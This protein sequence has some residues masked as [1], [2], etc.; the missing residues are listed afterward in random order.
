MDVSDQ[1][2][3]RQEIERLRTLINHHNHRYHVLDSPEI[4]DSEYDR[5]MRRL[6]QLEAE[7]PEL[8]TPDSPTRRVGAA[9]LEEF[10]TVE[11][12]LPLLS[13]ANVF[14]NEELLAWYKRVLNLRGKQD[15]DF[16]CEIKMDGLAVA[17]TYVDG[18]LVTGATRGDGFK[19]ED[20]TQNLKTVKSI[21]LS[22]P[23]DAP[24]RFEVRGEVYLPKAGFKKLND[25]RAREGLP[26]FVNP[27]NAAAGS[28][29]QLDPRVTAQ[30]PLDIYVY[31]LGDYEG[32]AVPDT[33][34]ERME[35]LK[36]L[37]F[38]INPRN[39]RCRTIEEVE[40]YHRDVEEHR[41]SLPYE[42]D[43]IVAKIDSIAIQDSL[44]YVAREPRWAVAYKFPAEQATTILKDI[45]VNVGR[46]GSLNPYAILEP[47]FVG[48][49]TIQSAALHNED[50]IRRKDIR[51]GD[52]VY[53]Q[54]AG[55]VIPEVVGPRIDPGAHRGEQFSMLKRTWE[56]YR[57]KQ[58]LAEN[59]TPP[60]HA[61]CPVC[62]AKVVREEG[63]AMHRCANAACPAQALER[64]KHFVG[65]M[66]IDG[67]GEKLCAAL[68]EKQFVKDVADIYRLKDR[69]EELI[70]LE[71][72]G[73]K[74]VDRILDSIDKSR[75]RPLAQLVFA[76][77]IPN[78]GSET[79]KL[80]VSR[81]SSLDELA[82]ATE[83]QL[84]NVQHVGHTIAKSIA[85]FFDQP[86]NK[87]IIEKLTEARVNLVRLKGEEP[88]QAK[89]GDLPLA[90]KEFVITGKLASSTRGE[91]EAKVKALGGTAGS[92]VTK[93]T[94]YVVVG[95]DPGS[96]LDKA[97]S[98]G[99]TVLTE[100][101]FLKMIGKGSST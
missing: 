74:S 93:K 69:R 34:W 35:Y 64:I 27:R 86:G 89:A 6:E 92:S 84:A 24:P 37:G 71:K 97:R 100:E 23:K 80:L 36:S 73:E 55:D 51:I 20:V 99:V 21:P 1:G 72:L 25:D 65:A 78:V 67:L 8:L 101:E 15:F 57:E 32:K 46:T 96:K 14:S 87:N 85:A 68:F 98:L 66:D 5:L 47:V 16:V 29:R 41:A 3:A 59:T 26:L 33:H 88:P 56:I 91:A 82:H 28:I 52:T 95:E 9:P 2:D 61:V 76:L 13:L 7:H 18:K 81:Y 62:G 17:L 48:G 30:R 60:P 22:A 44:G 58:G 19:G 50:D 54:R 11:H 38:K 42:T 53:V 40:A 45:G 43:G 77:G 90:G 49:V 79:A 39:K 31:A 10:G 70:R 4:S 12:R 75:F 63:E 94:S 83:D